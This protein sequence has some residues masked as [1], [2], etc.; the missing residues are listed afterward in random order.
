MGTSGSQPL[1]PNFDKPLNALCL[2]GLLASS[3]VMQRLGSALLTCRPQI[4]MASE[5]LQ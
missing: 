5:C 4:T 2:D 1:L 3:S